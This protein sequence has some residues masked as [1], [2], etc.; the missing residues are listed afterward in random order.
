MDTDSVVAQSSNPIIRLVT[1]LRLKPPSDGCAAG[2]ESSLLGGRGAAATKTASKAETCLNRT[3]IGF[4]RCLDDPISGLIS[5]AV[6]HF[7]AAT[8][9]LALIAYALLY[10]RLGGAEPIK[11]DGY[12]Y[13][14]YLP[15]WFIYK[16]VSFEALAADW[17]G[18]TYPSFA[19]VTRWPWTGRWINLHP[20][21]TAILE[22]PFFVVADILSRWSN[23][24]RDGFSVYYQHAAGLAGLTYFIAGLAILRGILARH[25]SKGVTLATLVCLTWGTN[26]FHYGVF[27]GTFSHAFAFFEICAWLWLVEHWWMDD[28]AR[29]SVMLGLIAG[30]IVLTRHTNAVFLLV[31]PLIG[32]TR[33][34]DLRRRASDAWRCR[35]SLLIAAAAGACVV[36]PQLALYKWTTGS[37]LVDAYVTHR[38]IGFRFASP[39]FAGVLFS[40]QKGLFFWSP[41]LLLSVVGFFVGSGWVSKLRLAAAVVLGI[42]TYLVA[43]WSEW[44]FGASYGHRAFTDGLGLMAIFLAACFEHVASRRYLRATVAVGAAAAVL[45][46][47]AQMIQYW[48]GILPY[49][50]T[51]W[52]QYRALF[53]R[54]R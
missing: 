7:I 8:A 1:K 32:I 11:S 43:S 25:F 41:L 23:M 20:I 9:L 22:V 51:T 39:H 10:G 21:G 28:T 14:V 46:S 18:G 19:G 24:P 40:T 4:R 27:D 44:Q 2:G 42:Q 53:L 13:Y 54:F 45:L 3:D 48:I 52:S 6:R 12:G 15:S 31:L 5:L 26:L 37:W 34:A 35:G 17:Y 47:I 30:L 38:P 29:R 50:D 36:A 33:V 16:D 49:A